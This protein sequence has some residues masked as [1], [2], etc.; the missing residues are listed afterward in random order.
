[1][2]AFISETN[3]AKAA[4]FKNNTHVYVL[5]A[6][7]SILCKSTTTT[8]KLYYS[9]NISLTNTIVWHTWQTPYYKP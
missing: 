8:S 9:W 1:M 4:K 3:R 2:N 5:Q 7:K 6:I